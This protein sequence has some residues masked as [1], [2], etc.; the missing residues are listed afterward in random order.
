M[1]LLFRT[2]VGKDF[3]G[4]EAERE[5]SQM[6]DMAELGSAEYMVTKIVKVS[7]DASWYTIGGR[8]ILFNCPHS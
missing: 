2:G 3:A 4:K 7:D 6:L 1:R 8:K 5:M